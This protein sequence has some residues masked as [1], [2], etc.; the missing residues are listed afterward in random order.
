M[1]V[2]ILLRGGMIFDGKNGHARPQRGDVAITGDRIAA[3]G[4]LSGCDAEHVVDVEGLC[5]SP[6]FIDVHAHSEFTLLADG[7]AEGKIC[8]GITTEVN[9][10]CGF[11]AAPLY[12]AVLEER[13]PELRSF[14]IKERWHTFAEYFR[15][16]RSRGIAVNFMTLVGHGNLRGSAAG[17]SD[18]N[19]SADERATL[20][21]FLTKSLEEGARGLSTG[22]VYAPGVYA[23][24]AEI[25]DIARKTAEHGGF[26]YTTHMRSEGDELL[27][28]MDEAITVGR[29]SGLHVHI[30]HLKTSG[31]RNWD[32]IGNALDKFEK[33]HAN[34][35]KLTCDRYPYTASCTSLDSILPSWTYEGGHEEEIRKI[36]NMRRE[37]EEEILR[38]S[39][40]DS[41]WKSITISRLNLV[42]NKWMEG[43]N[44]YEVSQ[45]SLKKPVQVL[46]DVLVEEKLDVDAIFFLMNE[47]NLK[48][49]LKSRYTVIGSDSSAR[50]FQSVTAAGKPHPRGFGTFPRI[51]GRYVREQNALTLE[52][53][54]YK[55]TGLPARIFRI[56]G[57]GIIKE[58]CF[59]DITVFDYRKI[60]DRAEFANPFIKPA[61]IHHV[62]VNGRPVLLNG[63]LTKELPGRILT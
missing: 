7:R 25:I 59:A 53:A 10:N 63:E 62:F 12:G 19:L 58:G 46:F 48:A 61:G 30:S 4:N 56:E 54:I 41:F 21:H 29:E 57:R 38:T 49:I 33:F 50:S 20:F 14:D 45:Y 26:I 47:K 34:D 22:L 28:A 2:D 15:L 1:N 39:P 23:D 17:Y 3:V 40:D 6:G 32:K 36:L 55:M 11:S 13:I 51:I 27:E 35:S 18:R 9:G 37:I 43:K 16:L 31:K 60:I 24:S 52:D 44:L 42:R 8:Q 5:V